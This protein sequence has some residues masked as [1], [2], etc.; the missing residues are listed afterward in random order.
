[1]KTTQNSSSLRAWILASRPK[2]LTA[3][4][5]PI[6]T[7]TALVYA[8]ELP[9]KWW[10]SFFA[11]LSSFCIQIATNFV[12][13]ASDFIK[14]AD[15][16]K[17]IGPQ[18][19]T[20]SGLFTSRQVFAMAAVFFALAMLFGIPLVIEG[21]WPIVILGLL[22]IFF[23]YAY[24]AGPFP[25]AYLGLGDLF[26]LLF[27]GFVAVSGLFFLH[28]HF[29]ATP[30]FILSMQV[31]LLATVLIAI[32]NLRDF[33]QDRE[34]HKRT[35]AVFLGITGARIE[36]TLLVLSPFVIGVY[37]WFHG[38]EWSFYLPFISLP[39]AIKILISIW[40]TPPSPA[41][42]QF[43]GMGAGL[44]LLF[45]LLISIGFILR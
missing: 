38:F 44:H 22:S 18:R 45:G 4:L 28:A 37:W 9:I 23:G 36:I 21:G 20:Q 39:L 26:V 1:M 10:V 8:L 3:A 14:G 16:E 2:T 6:I 41:Y 17:R 25:L 33:F 7:A 5:V 40:K 32:N 27:F 24:T 15:T 11:L 42:N 43:L 31:G 13:D 19:V 30:V 34:V 29:V 12:N 35:L